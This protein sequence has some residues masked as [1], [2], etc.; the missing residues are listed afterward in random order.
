MA[1]IQWL[2]AEAIKDLGIHYPMLQFLN[3]TQDTDYVLVTLYAGHIFQWS[4]EEYT[5]FVP[6]FKKLRKCNTE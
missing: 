6:L 2:H 5:D 4:H 1:D 3:S